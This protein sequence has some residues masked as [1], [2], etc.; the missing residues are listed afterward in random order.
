MACGLRPGSP[1]LRRAA[2]AKEGG[3]VLRLDS[4]ALVLP[5]L[6][7][8]QG[9]QP[10]EHFKLAWGIVGKLTHVGTDV[11]QYIVQVPV[12]KSVVIMKDVDQRRSKR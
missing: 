10:A 9:G 4:M 12:G 2:R 3:S 11:K 6:S 1:A 8:S 5:F 7:F